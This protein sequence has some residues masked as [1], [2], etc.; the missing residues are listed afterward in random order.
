[1]ICQNHASP[2]GRVIRKQDLERQKIIPSSRSTPWK[3]L[4]CASVGAIIGRFNVWEIR[5]SNVWR[6]LKKRRF[7]CCPGSQLLDNKIQPIYERHERLREEN[8]EPLIIIRFVFCSCNRTYTIY[9]L[10]NCK[11]CPSSIKS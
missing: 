9:F 11:L 2:P 6:F 10:V 5:G 8:A 7:C 4:V 1:M 3:L